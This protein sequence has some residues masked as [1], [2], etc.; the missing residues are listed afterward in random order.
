L[1]KNPQINRPSLGH[2]LQKLV[3]NS[4][5]FQMDYYLKNLHFIIM[6]MTVHLKDLLI[7]QSI[8]F[9]ASNFKLATNFQNLV[10]Q[11]FIQIYYC[12]VVL[13][14]LF[15]FLTGH[16]KDLSH[17]FI[18]NYYVHQ[19]SYWRILF[20]HFYFSSCFFHPQMNHHLI[21]FFIFYFQLLWFFILG[22]QVLQPFYCPCPFKFEHSIM[23]NLFFLM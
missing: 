2:H 11:D 18:L 15:P 21:L 19:T 13:M 7:N 6:L 4:I 9:I 17:F 14:Y 10:S 16:P 5:C 1:P 12:F 23:L 22:F 3:L 8:N 20:C